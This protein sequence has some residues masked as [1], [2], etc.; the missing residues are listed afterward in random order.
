MF[1]GIGPQL[2]PIISRQ[3]AVLGHCSTPWTSL[4]LSRTLQLMVY[5]FNASFFHYHAYL[6]IH[7][8]FD[9]DQLL[10][11]LGWKVKFPR[12][13]K[14]SLSP[15]DGA[16]TLSNSA[17][18]TQA[19]CLPRT[20]LLLQA[21][22]TL[23]SCRRGD[24]LGESL[25]LLVQMNDTLARI[26]WGINTI[27]FPLPQQP[28]G[29]K[30]AS[31]IDCGVFSLPQQPVGGK[32]SAIKNGGGGFVFPLWGVYNAFGMSLEAIGKVIGFLA[33]FW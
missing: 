22:C 19:C 5:F 7:Q 31:I 27:I 17:I 9:V 13:P 8:N 4:K 21:Y 15:N 29:G 6:G 1:W 33:W 10:I 24:L 11:S 14:P 26:F 3:E 28:V 20:L 18:S 12:L 23:V 30:T 32:N 2:S 16:D 25:A